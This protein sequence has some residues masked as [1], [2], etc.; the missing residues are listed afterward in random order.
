MSWSSRKVRCCD[1]T[2]TNLWF[3]IADSGFSFTQ[4]P[5][6]GAC[7]NIV[8]NSFN[9]SHKSHARLYFKQSHHHSH[10]SESFSTALYL[11]I[12]T[13][14]SL[15]SCTPFWLHSF[16]W[17]TACLYSSYS[18]NPDR[19]L[20]FVNCFSLTFQNFTIHSITHCFSKTNFA[21][22]IFIPHPN[23]ISWLYTNTP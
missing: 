5:F 9:V 17:N 23:H 1:P 19:F 16:T 15:S 7:R 14:A 13:I 21:A 8:A 4:T 3:N 2:F 22:H 12:F 18:P 6:S 11:K 20:F 10:H